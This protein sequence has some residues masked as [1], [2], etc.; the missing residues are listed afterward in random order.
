MVSEMLR[1]T[2]SKLSIQGVTKSFSG[3]SV[4]KDLNLEIP[5][6]KLVTILGAS[7]GGKT[8]LLRIIAGFETVD[9]GQVTINGR[10][11][12]SVDSLTPPEKRNVGFVPQDAA[13]FSHLNVAQNIA[14]G[15]SQFSADAKKRRV[16][17][18]LDLIDLTEFANAMPHQLSGGQQQRVAIARALAPSPDV[19]LMDEPFAALDAKLRSRLRDDVKSILRTAKATAILVTHDQEEALSIADKVAVLR[20]GQIAQFGSPN[21]IYA[22]PTDI[23]LAQFLGDAV[24]LP[25][26]V[27]GGKI[28]TLLGDL[29]PTKQF[30][31]GSQGSVAIRPENLYLQPN[32]N[33]DGRVVARQYFGHDALVEVEV[34][35]VAVK[36][37][38]TGPLTPELGMPVTVW[39]RG[40]V[41]F[42]PTTN[43]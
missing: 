5:E 19:I 12:T 10:V 13:L 30:A 29:I 43:F 27:V 36:A 16:A 34:R 14:F 31:D 40:S 38:T 8:T 4:L 32:I 21:E 18:L 35:G 1:E 41:N 22:A 33:G 7:G 11:V 9:S 25:G 42:Y 6:E 28:Q 37:R 23:A 24:V 2:N 15:L 39:V 3:L 17:E 26:E 20:D